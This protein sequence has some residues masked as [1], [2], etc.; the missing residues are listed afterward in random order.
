MR[1]ILFA[2]A[3]SL[4]LMSCGQPAKKTDAPPAEGV[5]NAATTM[6]LLCAGPFAANATRQMLVDEFGAEHV[7][8][9]NVPGP[10]GTVDN[11]TVIYPGDVTKRAEV[12]WA[13]DAAKA[14]PANIK[15]NHLAT[16]WT[17]PSGLKAGMTLEDVEAIN[18]KPFTIMGFNWDYG[19]AVTD[20]KGGALAGGD[21]RVLVRFDPEPGAPTEKVMGDRPF[22]SDQADVRAAKP[23]VSEISIGYPQPQ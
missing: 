19:G 15:I 7:V 18:T 20:W 12:I 6:S 13:D 10:E 2:A 22:S 23:T 14:R 8:D 21:C 11:A 9:M 1:A 5:D 4:A 16:A 3:A 17:G